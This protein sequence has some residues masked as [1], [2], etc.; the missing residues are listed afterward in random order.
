LGCQGACQ[1]DLD[2]NH[3]VVVSDILLFLA[4]YGSLCL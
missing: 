4:M 1:T 3:N 2:S